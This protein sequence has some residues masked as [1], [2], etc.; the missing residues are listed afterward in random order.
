MAWEPFIA[1]W[2]YAPIQ[3]GKEKQCTLFSVPNTVAPYDTKNKYQLGPQLE[4]LHESAQVV[5]EQVFDLQVLWEVFEFR[6]AWLLDT[7]VNTTHGS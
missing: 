2:P 1:K 3:L 6:R 4:L 5:I 7:R